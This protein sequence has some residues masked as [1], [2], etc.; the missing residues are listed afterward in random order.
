[1]NAINSAFDG[2]YKYQETINSAWDKRLPTYPDRKQC[3]DFDSKYLID[4]SKYQLM[5]NAVQPVV[6]VPLYYSQLET[7]VHIAVDVIPTKLHR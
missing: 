4:S 7:I 5:D 2:P 1:M 6:Q 3:R